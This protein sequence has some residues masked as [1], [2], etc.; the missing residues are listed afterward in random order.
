MFTSIIA[1]SLL[2]PGFGLQPVSITQTSNNT[3]AL[4]ATQDTQIQISHDA[5]FEIIVSNNK[6][7]FDN[8]DGK[9]LKLTIKKNQ[10]YEID[11]QTGFKSGYFKI[12][13][14]KVNVKAYWA[15]F[16]LIIILHFYKVILP[17]K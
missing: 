5:G 2:F 17:I 10:K 16:I 4:Y 7:V 14:T 9:G 11:A 13:N 8:Q 12:N 6:Q 3:I 15:F 1:S